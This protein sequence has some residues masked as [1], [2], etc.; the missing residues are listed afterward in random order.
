MTAPLGRLLLEAFTWFDDSLR[1]SLSD[2]GW[3]PLTPAQS[4]VMAHIDPSGTRSAEIARRVGVSRQAVHRTVSE[5]AD[6]GLV[7]LDPDPS[8][9]SAS[10]VLL[11]TRGEANVKAALATFAL[12]EDELASRIGRR[13]VA[14]LRQALERPRSEPVVVA[15]P[16]PRR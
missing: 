5:L 15:S 3:P 7:R 9:A 14:S 16:K 1:A 12:L 2:A 13:A 11:T 8:N 6:M 4:L 10:L